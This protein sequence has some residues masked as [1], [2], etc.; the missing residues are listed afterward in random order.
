MNKKKC[1]ALI[2]VVVCIL[3]VV[4]TMLIFRMDKTS[5]LEDETISAQEFANIVS[6]NH[7]F[8]DNGRFIYA[9]QMNLY[10]LY[11]DH[12]NFSDDE[13]MPVYLKIYNTI[14][15]AA[16]EYSGYEYVPLTEQE[17]NRRQA[18]MIAMDIQDLLKDNSDI[19]DMK[20]FIKENYEESD[21]TYDI[22]YAEYFQYVYDKIQDIP[23]EVAKGKAIDGATYAKG[24]EELETWDSYIAFQYE[25][26]FHS[27]LGPHASILAFVPIYEAINGKYDNMPEILQFVEDYNSAMG[28]DNYNSKQYQYWTCLL[29]I[30]YS[31]IAINNNLEPPQEWIEEYEQYKKG[32]LD[33]MSSWILYSQGPYWKNPDDAEHI[34]Y[35]NLQ[36]FLNQVMMGD[37][38]RCIYFDQ[39]FVIEVAEGKFV[40]INPEESEPDYE[41]E[42][43]ESNHFTYQEI[44]GKLYYAL[45]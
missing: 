18:G 34:L 42:L 25:Y 24:L 5:Q 41:Y 3:I 19:M 20:T 36:R 33:T 17:Y 35:S 38:Y 39:P 26:M 14:E 30:M 29:Q 8:D 16:S 7:Y 44:R 15:Q 32:E 27:M 12:K 37:V 2:A 13:V 23:F 31:E 28:N 4:S 21:T 22:P 10:Q 40:T 43:R 11:E 9:E 45:E 6:L 1:I